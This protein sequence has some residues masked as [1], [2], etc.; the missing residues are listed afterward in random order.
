MSS[1]KNVVC[2]SIFIIHQHSSSP[3]LVFTRDS[4]FSPLLLNY[5]YVKYTSYSYVYIICIF[6]YLY[7]INILVRVNQPVHPFTPPAQRVCVCVCMYEDVLLL[8]LLLIWPH[9]G[10]LQRGGTFFLH[11]Y[12]GGKIFLCKRGWGQQG[13]TAGRRA[14][15]VYDRGKK[16]WPEVAF[17]PDLYTRRSCD[18]CTCS[19]PSFSPYHPLRHIKMSHRMSSRR[20]RR[21]R[22]WLGRNVFAY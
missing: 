11:L 12:S 6:F 14:N 9:A 13:G 4:V 17:F 22:L 7:R 3:V 20:R 19:L 2:D 18:L 15:A 16:G 10:A 5:V 1:R 8:L 21:R